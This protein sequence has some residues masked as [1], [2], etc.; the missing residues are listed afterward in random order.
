MILHCTLIFNVTASD[1]DGEFQRFRDEYVTFFYI[2]DL[3]LTTVEVSGEWD[4]WERH[5]MTQV[6]NKYSLSLVLEPGYYCYKF[7]ISGSEWIADPN[8]NYKKYC[9]G[10]L[11]SGIVVE[12]YTKPELEINYISEELLNI[13]IDYFAGFGGTGPQNFDIYLINNFNHHN[14][15]YSWHPSTWTVNIDLEFDEENYDFGKYTL[16]L[17]ATDMDGVLSNELFIPFWFEN[18][19]YDWNGA[20]IYMVMTDRFVN[21]N[22]SNDPEPLPE[23]SV[24]TDWEG[25][26]FAGIISSLESGYFENLGV[27]AIWMS[28]FNSAATGTFFASDNSHMVSS[29]HGYWPIKAREIDPRLGTPKELRE[30]VAL[31]HSQGI[32]VMNDFVINHVHQDHEYFSSY[33]DW[34]RDGCLLGTDNCDWTEHALD[35]VFRSYMPDVNWQ[36]P[37]ASERFIEDAIWWQKEFD[38]D[39]SRIDA[40]KHVES[41]A[42][43]NLAAKFKLELENDLTDY[44]LLGETAMG[45]NGD[46]LEDNLAE[47]ETINNY[48]GEKGLDGQGDFVLYHAVVDNVFRYGVKDYQHLDYWTEQSQL[49]YVEGSIMTPYLGSHDTSRL[50]S[51]LDTGGYNPDNKWIEES[52]PQVPSSSEPY[53]K[54]KLAFSW[55]LTIPGAPVLYMG[56]EYGEYGGSDP[57]NR[58]SFRSKEYLSDN[59]KDL[60]TFVSSMSNIRKN[61]SDL[62][63]GSYRSIFSDSTLIVFSRE[64]AKS[65]TIVMINSGTESRKMD[66]IF[67]TDI[68]YNSYNSLIDNESVIGSNVLNFTVEPQEVAIFTSNFNFVNETN[69]NET[70]N[71]NITEG[72]DIIE[73]DIDEQDDVAVIQDDLNITL[74]EDNLEENNDGKKDIKKG[75]KD[76]QGLLILRSILLITF[77]SL[78][79]TFVYTR[80]G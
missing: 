34:F 24:G 37:V 42:V 78:I 6:D 47:Y 50:I 30:L 33:P 46:D 68:F 26:D 64:T 10:I 55:L 71:T 8:N 1:D 39:G 41:L 62:S 14:V 53:Q 27:S 38:L 52:L 20:L 74:E 57:D 17:Q 23:A 19:S 35:G 18:Y 2:S 79:L 16:F 56:D 58:H 7:I 65:E 22:S 36:N 66:F 5:N 43:S 21:G 12:D 31:A 60:L 4:N 11:N 70:D 76:Q 9:N 32:R 54:S 28:P 45:W 51:R 3:P 63:L 29:Y 48:L 25:G 59:E 44:Y 72:Q 73:V 67:D 15:T 49:N 69:F 13:S 61:S 77:L 40:V 80:G 75:D